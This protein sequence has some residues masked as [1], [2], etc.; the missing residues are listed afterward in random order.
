MAKEVKEEKNVKEGIDTNN[1]VVKEKMSYEELSNVAHQLSEQAKI[2]YTKLQ[3]ANMTNA[4]KRLDYLFKV[5]ENSKLYFEYGKTEFVNAAMD[6]IQ[7]IITLPQE[8][9][10]S[11]TV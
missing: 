5:L 9:V 11:E 1:N 6:E 7:A 10:Q 4:F 8:E 3:E 2:L